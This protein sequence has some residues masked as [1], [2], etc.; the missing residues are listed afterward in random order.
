MTAEEDYPAEKLLRT[1]EDN[2]DELIQSQQNSLYSFLGD[3]HQ[4]YQEHLEEALM[5]IP[6]S[7]DFGELGFKQVSRAEKGKLAGLIKKLDKTSDYEGKFVT[8]RN[9][10]KKGYET[11]LNYFLNALNDLTTDEEMRLDMGQQYIIDD[12][13]E[14]HLEAVKETIKKKS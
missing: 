12:F 10:S 14:T 6:D 8:P 4:R 5:K 9:S 1:Y 11:E 3:Q 7:W 13:T 2:W